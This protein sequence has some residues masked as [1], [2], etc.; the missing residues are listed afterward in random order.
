[1]TISSI[2]SQ[3]S[4][5]PTVGASAGTSA[6]D[7]TASMQDRFL[8]LLVAQINNQDPLSPMDNAQMTSQM[9]QINTVSG[10]Q[11]VNQTLT[12]MAAQF[13][14]MQVLQG[15][16]MVGHNVLTS[17]STLVP[18][19]GTGMAVAAFDLAGN[20]DAVKVEILAPSGQVLD[21]FNL[22]ALPQGRQSFQWNAASYQGAG[23]PSFRV[24][25][26]QGT[27]AIAAA[28]LVS[29]QVISVGSVNGAM[30]IQLQSGRSVGYADIAAIL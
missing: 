5:A 17:G 22:G 24:T 30:S 19:A 29:E 8:K 15:T 11:Q 2:N 4:P 28:P 1:M 23:S 12:S 10:I 14:T 25:A 16:S 9:A 18:N 3:T 20:A 13:A 27:Q 6:T 7:T 26:T 21:A